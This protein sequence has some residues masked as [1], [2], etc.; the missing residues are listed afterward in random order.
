MSWLPGRS[1]VTVSTGAEAPSLR[2]SGT[3]AGSVPPR[4]GP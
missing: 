2:T 1:N 4:R 3:P